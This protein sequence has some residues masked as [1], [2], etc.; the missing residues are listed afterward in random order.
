MS[1]ISL[2]PLGDKV[3]VRQTENES[4]TES[5]IILTNDKA[6]PFTGEVVAVGPG[7]RDEK[8]KFTPIGVAIGDKVLMSRFGYDEVIVGGERLL[9]LPEAVII[10]ILG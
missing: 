4:K 1:N 10:G 5:G 7:K 6:L 2:R 3:V 9:V 8:G